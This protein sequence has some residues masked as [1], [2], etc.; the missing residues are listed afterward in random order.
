L[1]NDL[2]R[3]SKSDCYQ[4]EA[5]FLRKNLSAGFAAVAAIGGHT[6]NSRSRRHCGHWATV[7]EV[8]RMTGI[9]GTADIDLVG[10]QTTPLW[11]GQ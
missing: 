2:H 10:A 4:P 3:F 7:P 11:P 8:A 1:G 9:E 5:A 6:L